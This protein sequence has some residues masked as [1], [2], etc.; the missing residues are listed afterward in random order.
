V[1]QRV[2]TQLLHAEPG[3]CAFRCAGNVVAHVWRGQMTDDIARRFVRINE[4]VILAHPEGISFVSWIQEGAPLPSP[5]ARK[6]VSEI[7]G[8]YSSSI[9]CVAVIAEGSGFWAS[10]MRSAAT[11]IGLLAKGNFMMRS[12]R[13]VA[14]M[15][16]W[17]PAHHQSRTGVTVAAPDLHELV[18]QAKRDAA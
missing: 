8:K 13:S 1:N 4:A 12:H 11:G 3:I 9:A 5:G 15:M 10:A 7:M 2:T 18:I 17:F 6:I 16:T 14:E